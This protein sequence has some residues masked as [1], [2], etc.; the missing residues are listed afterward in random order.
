MKSVCLS[1][2]FFFG[3]ILALS[4]QDAWRDASSTPSSSRASMAMGKHEGKKWFMMRRLNVGV[5]GE[6]M[7]FYPWGRERVK[8][9][10]GR[11]YIKILYQAYNLLKKSNL[12]IC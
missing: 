12:L 1:V 7:S 10:E 4:L 5:E 9:P 2:V 11:A 8:I 6:I 3:G